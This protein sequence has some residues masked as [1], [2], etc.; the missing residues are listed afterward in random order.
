MQAETSPEKTR[1]R[2]T[3]AA[4]VSV[5]GYGRRRTGLRR[6][7]VPVV[8]WNIALAAADNQ[9]RNPFAFVRPADHSDS[10]VAHPPRGRVGR[11]D[12]ALTR[13]CAE[14]RPH[15]LNLFPNY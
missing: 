3:E 11:L 12:G 4:V 2:V 8:V 15:T 7:V 13:P 6:N 14:V 5:H 10:S 1:Y 9:R